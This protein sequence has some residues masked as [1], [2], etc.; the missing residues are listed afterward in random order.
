MK[1][2]EAPAVFPLVFDQHGVGTLT[3][4]PPR[5]PLFPGCSRPGTRDLPGA[6]V[7]RACWGSGR[8]LPQPEKRGASPW[9]GP[10]V[11]ARPRE[12]VLFPASRV[13]LCL[14]VLLYTQVFSVVK[15]R[16]WETRS[17]SIFVNTGAV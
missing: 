5:G 3:G 1:K 7:P 15:L 9:G 11:Y 16:S 2:P 4:F 17:Y 10:L 6:V 12:A 13:I 14:L 8:R